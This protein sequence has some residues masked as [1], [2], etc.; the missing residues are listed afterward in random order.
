MRRP[1]HAP[2][3]TLRAGILNRILDFAGNRRWRRLRRRCRRQTKPIGSRP[4]WRSG[5]S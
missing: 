1:R 5:Q 2:T 4:F 3:S